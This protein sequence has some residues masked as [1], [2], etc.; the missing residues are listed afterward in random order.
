MRITY[1]AEAD[2]VYIYLTEIVKE[3]D[4][5]EVD[6]DIALDFDEQER[7]MGIEILEASKRLDLD[8]MLPMA[9]RLDERRLAWYKLREE[10]IRRKTAG[11]PVKTLDREVRNWIE[12]IGRDY[13]VVL[14]EESRSGKPRKITARDLEDKNTEG[15]KKRRI[16]S[17]THALRKVGG[18]P[19]RP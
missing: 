15:L 17:I 10:L 3:P 1:D 5:R 16:E 9:E 4:A 13:V 6:D 8:Y 14:S 12:E 18:Y 11:E 7:L 2:A 19:E